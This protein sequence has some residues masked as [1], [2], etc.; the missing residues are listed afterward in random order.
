MNR[1]QKEMIH[2]MRNEGYSFTK[3]ADELNISV[4]TIKSYCRRIKEQHNIKNEK[5]LCCKECSKE[6]IQ[7]EG[8]KEKKF[9]NDKCRLTWWSK[10]TDKLKK[11]AMYEFTCSGCG[12]KFQAYGNNKRKYCSHNC[13]I[14][15]RFNK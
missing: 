8:K 14:E 2:K 11:K 4:N 12:K 6:I 10:N 9:C 7:Q 1:N 3:I 15:D 5:I 13:Y